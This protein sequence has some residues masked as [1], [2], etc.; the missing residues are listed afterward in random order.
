KSEPQLTS[1]IL[2]RRFGTSSVGPLSI[3]CPSGVR[4]LARFLFPPPEGT[5][6]PPSSLLVPP[7]RVPPRLQ[8]GLPLPGGRPAGSFRPSRV[9]VLAFSRRSG[10]LNGGRSQVIPATP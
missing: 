3:T 1:L 6:A 10:P 7:P 8:V 4:V 9:L 5:K 2:T